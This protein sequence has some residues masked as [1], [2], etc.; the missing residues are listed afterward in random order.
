MRLRWQPVSIHARH[1]WRAR[2]RRAVARAQPLIVSIHARHY[3][4]ARRAHRRPGAR[5][6]QVSIHARHYW[7][8][9]PDYCISCWA[10]NP[11]QSTPAI[12]GGR[13]VAQRADHPAHTRFNP[14]PPLLAG[15]TAESLRRALARL[16]SIH[17]RHYWRARRAVPS[18]QS[19]SRTVSIHARHYW[20]ARRSRAT[21][22]PARFRFNPRPPLL[23]GETD[24]GDQVGRHRNV[25]IHARH[26]W[27]ARLHAGADHTRL[28]AVSIHA[29]HYWRA[30]RCFRCGH[31]ALRL[32]SIHARHYWRARQHWR[33]C[34]GSHSC[35]NPRPPLLAGETL[36]QSR[37]NHQSPCFNPRPPLLA[38][39]TDA[40]RAGNIADHVSIHA[41]H[42]WRARPVHAV[43]LY[44]AHLVSI[45]AR[46][47]WRARPN[48]FCR[49]CTSFLFQSTPA[50][51]GGRDQ[52]N[53]NL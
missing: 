34:V 22:R 23:A 6:A 27:R 39:E 20:R 38:G 52:S 14:R 8:A 32:V 51:T 29:R 40:G 1:Y 19:A 5:L 16:V 33:C 25:S 44:R 11:F 49:C 30:R 18:P 3:W 37:Q 4:R 46:H 24:L 15:E 28:D 12:T 13:D 36:C 2:L 48:V 10:V 35:F 17:A 7:R 9:R 26:Y 53:E 45:H 42:Y 43:F 50:I 21:L 41:R 31:A 47:Y